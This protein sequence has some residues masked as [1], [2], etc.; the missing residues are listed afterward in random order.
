LRLPAASR[1]IGSDSAGLSRGT[2]VQLGLK[3]RC[4]FVGSSECALGNETI[5]SDSCSILARR[6]RG[7]LVQLCRRAL[8]G[9][10]GL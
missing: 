10:S 2:L 8:N 4:G 6:S 3:Y 9:G 1:G 5:F 7:N